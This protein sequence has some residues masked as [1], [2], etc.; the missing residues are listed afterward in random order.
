MRLEVDGRQFFYSPAKDGDVIINIDHIVKAVMLEGADMVLHMSNGDKFT[1]RG[2]I[3][4]AMLLT[5][6]KRA[7]LPTEDR[8]KIIIDHAR[9]VIDKAPQG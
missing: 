5:L 7:V 6:A 9:S 8:V 4:A 3:A 2:E 1:L